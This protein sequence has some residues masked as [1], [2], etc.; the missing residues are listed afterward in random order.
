MTIL[1]RIVVGPPEA[2]GSASGRE[3]GKEAVMARRLGP[4]LAAIAVLALAGCRSVGR[5][6]TIDP[7]DYA[8]SYFNGFY[9]QVFQFNAAQVESSAL[10][11]LGDLGFTKIHRKLLGDGRV[12]IK[13]WTLD[14]R[15]ACL[16][17][18]PRNEAMAVLTIYVGLIGDE[19]VSQT[20]MER[21]SLNFGT[22]PRVMIPMEPSLE[23]R[24]NPTPPLQPTLPRT[25]SIPEERLPGEPFPAPAAAEVRAEPAVVPE[26]PAPGPGPGPFGPPSL[27]IPAPTPPPPA[28]I[29]G[30]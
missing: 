22:I 21:V 27:P 12:E 7:S 1:A 13:C 29:P 8:Y 9:S 17:V 6:P 23:R 30:A 18:K 10:Q 20:V 26:P 2:D 4:T 14:H 25:V 16:W 15:P 5:F 28:P 11:A 3:A 19:L 24:F